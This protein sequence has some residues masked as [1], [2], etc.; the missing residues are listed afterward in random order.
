[1]KRKFICVKWNKHRINMQYV[2]SLTWESRSLDFETAGYQSL[3]RN[4]TV[5][6]WALESVVWYYLKIFIASLF[7]LWLCL[8]LSPNVFSIHHDTYLILLLNTDMY[9]L[10]RHL[11]FPESLSN[12]LCFPESLKIRKSS[13][14][15]KISYISFSSNF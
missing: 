3:V 8:G 6:V 12:H 2:I 10:K 4:N 1:M 15:S 11:Y 9:N 14:L 13:L 7:F 5:C